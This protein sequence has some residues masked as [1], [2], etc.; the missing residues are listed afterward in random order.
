[1]GK[2]WI[3]FLFRALVKYSPIE[4][5]LDVGAGEG[6]Y[7]KLKVEGQQEWTAVEVWAPYV[8]E[9]E[10]RRKYDRV[11]VADAYYVDYPMLGRFDLAFLGDVLEHMPKDRAVSVVDRV[12]DVTRQ[13]V[14]SIPVVP[15]AQDEIEGNPYQ[16]HVKTDWN[17]D[18]VMESF[19]HICSWYIED[20]IGAYALSKN[21][22][23]A[24][25]LRKM[26]PDVA[27][28]V[29]RRRGKATPSA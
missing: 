15:F 1:L 20:Q 22:L 27:E 7:A 6:T 11:V 18:E 13:A 12:L 8:E 29:K 2:D 4:R 25:M 3:Q 26:G 17:H 5:V 9:Y 28:F 21:P 16:R 23:E 19:P 24:E 14:I 10:L